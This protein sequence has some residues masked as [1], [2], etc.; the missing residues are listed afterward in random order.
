MQVLIAVIEDLFQFAHD[1]FSGAVPYNTNTQ[2]SS[3]KSTDSVQT[4]LTSNPKTSSD[5][6]LKPGEQYYIG[7]LGAYMYKDPVLAFDNAIIKLDYGQ[8]VRLITLQGRWA[9]VRLAG[10]VGWVFKDSLVVQTSDVYPV[11]IQ[12]I[13]YDAEQAETVK[14]RACIDDAFN[15]AVSGHVLSAAEYVHYCLLQKKLYIDWGDIRMRIPGTWQRKLRGRFGVHIGISPQTNSVMEYIVDDVGH[16][17][18]VDAAFSDG[19]ISITE[20]GKHEE[21]M[22]SQDT[23]SADQWRE[24]RPVFIKVV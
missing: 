4:L 20:I 11:F 18:F 1:A 9:Q 24:L 17:A 2:T 15:G 19:S 23:M 8:N 21:A 10:T 13:V 6:N 5:K 3:C 16:L 12:G 22:Y 7:A 14:L